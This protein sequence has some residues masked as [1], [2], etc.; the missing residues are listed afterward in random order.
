MGRFWNVRSHNDS[1]RFGYVLERTVAQR[2]GS[3]WVG[4]GAYACAT[5]WNDLGR[6]WNVRFATILI[7]LDWCWSRLLRYALDRSGEVLERTLSPP[8]GTIW[9]GL[10][11]VFYS[12][13][14]ARWTKEYRV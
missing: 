11:A 3:I 12:L 8:F 9:V 6:F 5:I 10:E 1:A 2:F 7:P 14:C 13:L 4:F